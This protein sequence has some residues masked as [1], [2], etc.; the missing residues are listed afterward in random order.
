M[1]QHGVVPGSVEVGLRSFQ[2]RTVVLWNK[3]VKSKVN[4][5][6]SRGW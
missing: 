6:R 2:T 3:R 4:S 5:H 1:A